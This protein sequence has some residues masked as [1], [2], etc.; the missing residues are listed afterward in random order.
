MGTSLDAR[1]R[2]HGGSGVSHRLDRPVSITVMKSR[3]SEVEC[4]PDKIEVGGS[5]PPGATLGRGCFR[6]NILPSPAPWA[7]S[8]TVVHLLCKQ[9]V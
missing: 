1:T 8:T 7:R 9:A 6:L 3:N 4:D 2:V 5:I